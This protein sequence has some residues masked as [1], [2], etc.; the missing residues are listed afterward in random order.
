ML[1]DIPFPEMCVTVEDKTTF[2]SEIIEWADENFKNEEL[3]ALQRI[4]L[5]HIRL[6]HWTESI[7]FRIDDET[8]AMAF[9]LRFF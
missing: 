1:V 4:R 6:N 9:K 2:I 5:K 7:S 3:W 8:D